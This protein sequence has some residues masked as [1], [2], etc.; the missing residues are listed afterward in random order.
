MLSRSPRVLPFYSCEDMEYK[1]I[2]AYKVPS[3]K[4]FYSLLKLLCG[5]ALGLLLKMNDLRIDFGA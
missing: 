4:K 2:T 5:I 3:F 1:V